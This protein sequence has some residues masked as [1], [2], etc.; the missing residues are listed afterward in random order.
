MSEVR[1]R[2]LLRLLFPVLLL[3]LAGCQV[4][5]ARGQPGPSATARAQDRRVAAADAR[6]FAGDYDGAEAAYR[7]LADARVP[8]GASH[9]STLLAYETRF[10]EAVAAAQQ[11]VELSADGDSLA[12]LTRALDWSEQLDAAVAAGA[13]AVAARPTTALAR[14][15]YSEA[16]A[17]S[18]QFAASAHQLELAES[19]P[20]DRHVQAEIDREWS[21]YYRALGDIQSELNYTELAVRAEPAFP[22]RQLDLIRYDYGNQRTDAART[23]TDRLLAAHPRN[24][25]L[26]LAAAD[27]AL[28]G[29]DSERA[30]SLYQAAAAIHADSA[31]AALGQA[32]L[33]VVV[34]HDFAAAHDLVLQALRLNAGSADLYQYVRYL[35]LLVLGRDPAADLAL[36]D[37]Q[38]PPD[39]AASR[40]ALLDQVNTVRSSLGLAA[41]REDPALDEAATAHAY[42]LLFNAGQQQTAG[43][44]VS[45]ED[46]SL[47]GFVAAAVLDRDRHFG[48]AG[49]R[50][51]ELVSNRFTPTGDAEGWL[52]GVFHRLPLLDRQTIA[53][54]FGQA[55]LGPL[56]YAA[57][58]VGAAAPTAG[59][60]VMYPAANQRGVPP[61]FTGDEVPDPLPQDALTPT[62]YPIT[63]QVGDAQKLAVARG[64]LLGP[65]GKEVPTY[66]LGPGTPVGDGQW[67]LIPE[68]PLGRGTY[69]VEVT[70]TVDGQDISENWSFTVG[71]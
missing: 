28:A 32:E 1:G 9:L 27:A 20:R 35:D 59:D 38:P 44:D 29:G 30:P 50:A 26:L 8:G 7:A 4:P 66:T 61:A 54:G 57:A 19:M 11:G 2:G 65:D 36:V 51:A 24:Y 3:P 46:A 47:P 55:G 14:A 6:L 40:K 22:E 31:G 21:N 13:R 5:A 45:V 23:L 71:S 16:L 67:A 62:G 37:P 49:S 43:G 68:R 69:S 63:V 48:Y 18:G 33:A 41:V 60:P 39:V 53:I 56:S 70:G 58:D 15:F 64:R 34:S 42:Y 25:R 12:R 10:S 52:D 17:D